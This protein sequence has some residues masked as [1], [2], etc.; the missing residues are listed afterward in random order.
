MCTFTG[1]H[2]YYNITKDTVCSSETLFPWFPLYTGGQLIG[3]GMN[4]FGHLERV[5]GERDWFEAPGETGVQV[6]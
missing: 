4:L 6:I 2:Y 5:D 3:M 1:Q